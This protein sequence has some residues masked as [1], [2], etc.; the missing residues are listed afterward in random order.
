MRVRRIEAKAWEI[1]C[2]RKF[3]YAGA[4][5]GATVAAWKQAARAEVAAAGGK[6]YGQTLLDLVKAFERIPFRV[7]LREARRFALSHKD[8][9]A[10]HRDVHA[11]ASHPG[12][13]G[14]LRPCV[15]NGASSP[16][17]GLPPQR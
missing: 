10:S 12:R 15:G 17:P 7:L 13:H 16:G 8:D 6:Q 1:S 3:L 9:K 2:D 11:A 14:L 5:R 4:D